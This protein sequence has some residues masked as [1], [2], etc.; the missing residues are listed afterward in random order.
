MKRD[1]QGKK[2]LKVQGARRT[3]GQARDPVVTSRTMG[4]IRS[5]DT[6]CELALRKELWRRGLRF[7]L[8]VRR[9]AG[10][11]LPGRPD[12][13]FIRARVAVFVDGDFW[14]GRLLQN[15]QTAAFTSCFRP[16]Q[17]KWWM[18][19]ISGNIE[20]DIRVT[21][22]LR[23]NGWAVIRVWE[24]DLLRKMKVIAGRIERIV[25]RRMRSTSRASAV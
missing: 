25:E 14:H 17:R 9:A 20:R 10:D 16:Q 24:T 1:G 15:G 18:K 8:Y 3:R 21:R 19:K 11:I 23:S 2:Q 4:A 5:Q 22:L 13:V 7:R 6:A 12:L